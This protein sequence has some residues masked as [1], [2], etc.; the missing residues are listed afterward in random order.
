MK[1]AAA[2]LMPL[3]VAGEEVAGELRY[4][5]PHAHLPPLRPGDRL[6]RGERWLFG[7]VGMELKESTA[8]AVRRAL[9]GVD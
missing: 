7:V 5:T 4:T 1:A 3:S 9:D 8:R 2:V 6:L